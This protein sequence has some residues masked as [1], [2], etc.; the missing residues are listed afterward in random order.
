MRYRL[1]VRLTS[2]D[3]GQ[4][5]VIRWRPPSLDDTGQM[6]DVLG[7][8]EKADTESLAVRTRDGTL[9]VIP[10][11]RAVAGKVIPPPPARRPRKHPQ[12]S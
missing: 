3:A 9:V 6:T 11:T 1:E 10:R 2:A 8:L 5:V 4:R 7:V 12:P